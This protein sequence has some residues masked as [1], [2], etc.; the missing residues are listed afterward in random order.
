LYVISNQI[1][2]TDNIAKNLT[3]ICTCIMFMRLHSSH[4]NQCGFWESKPWPFAG[5][6][7]EE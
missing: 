2:L 1:K 7:T 6:Y 5:P 4:H 3:D